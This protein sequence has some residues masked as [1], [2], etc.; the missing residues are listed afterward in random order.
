MHERERFLWMRSVQISAF[1]AQSEE[2][3]ARLWAEAQ[4][5]ADLI[6][7]PAENDP[8]PAAVLAETPGEPHE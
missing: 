4:K 5:A 6:Y 2:E 8:D 3:D 7:G 1:E